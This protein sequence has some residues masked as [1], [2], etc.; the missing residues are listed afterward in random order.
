MNRAYPQAAFELDPVTGTVVW[1]SQA[2]SVEAS[3]P[4][5]GADRLSN[6]NTFLIGTTAI[7][8]MTDTGQVVWRFVLEGE[9]HRGRGGPLLGFYKAERVGGSKS[10]P[11]HRASRE[12]WQTPTRDEGATRTPDLRT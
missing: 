2:A 6:G 8:E 7:L 9:M 12:G 1:T 4:L 10:F 11:T 5:C 3:L